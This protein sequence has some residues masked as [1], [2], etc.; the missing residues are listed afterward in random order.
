[1]D[2]N[3]KINLMQINKIPVPREMYAQ[4]I[5]EMAAEISQIIREL[6]QE[7]KDE[8]NARERK[9]MDE[10]HERH[11][12]LLDNLSPIPTVKMK[13]LVDKSPPH[14]RDFSRELGGF[15]CKM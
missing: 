15:S 11:K 14:T 7:E 9:Q 5:S 1:M 2:I 6:P 13:T 3:K 12:N 8:I 10:F 4:G